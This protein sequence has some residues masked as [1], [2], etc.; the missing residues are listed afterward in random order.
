MDVQVTSEKDVFDKGRQFHPAFSHQFFG[1]SET[2]F[3]YC[4]LEVQLYYHAGTLLTYLGLTY[5]SNING[6][7]AD[8]IEADPVVQIIGEQFPGG[9]L[10]NK[11]EFIAKLPEQSSFV[12]MGELIHSYQR[13]GKDYKIYSCDTM[14]PRFKD[15]HTRLQTFILWFIDAASYI[16]IDDER[17]H[18]YLLFEKSKEA[19]DAQYSIVGYMSVYHYY[20]YPDKMRPRVSQMLILPPFQKCGHGA[21]LLRT[22]DEQYITNPQVLDITVEDPSED[23]V[24][25]RDYV[26]CLACSKLDCFSPDKLR[27][28]F[29]D[30]MA[31]EARK[32]RK[33]SKL[34]CRRVYE[35]LR[36]KVTDRSNTAEYRDYRLDIKKRLNMPYQKQK[37]DLDKLQKVL[38][39][40]EMSA[41][42][43]LQ[44]RH[45]RLQQLDQT[46]LEVEEGYMKT[47]E[48]L[49]AA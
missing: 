37:S 36:L 26:D 38:S 47:L 20:A 32:A 8:G 24:R 31:E 34:Q 49:A 19:G 42:M 35:I 25:L 46:Y 10:T 43:S 12:P 5:E 3:G 41:A 23:F 21:E 39:T 18:F 44:S 45:E 14:T 27:A 11:D 33:I 29:T 7:V 30:S 2:I 28:G 17:W 6:K 4:G 13:M 15:Y 9:F 16:D 40:E 1:D 22:A 48:R